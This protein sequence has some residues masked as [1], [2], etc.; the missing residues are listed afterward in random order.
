MS[1]DKE[2]KV[3]TMRTLSDDLSRKS[4]KLGQLKGKQERRKLDEAALR[5]AQDQLVALQSDLRV[6]K[7]RAKRLTTLDSGTDS[8][9]SERSIQRE[10]ECVEHC[11][12][13]TR[14]RRG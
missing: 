4:V 2:L 10:K 7:S 5:E 6:R 14:K 12:G 11:Q 3:T 13:G 9:I 1:S 8:A